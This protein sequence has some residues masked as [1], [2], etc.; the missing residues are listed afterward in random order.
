VA[1]CLTVKVRPRECDREVLLD[2]F[3]AYIEAIEIPSIA[4]FA[5]RGAC[6]G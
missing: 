6:A 5:Y 2:R 3:E 4:E 1:S